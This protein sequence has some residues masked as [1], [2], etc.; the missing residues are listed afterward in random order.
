MEFVGTEHCA[1]CRGQFPRRTARGP[2]PWQSNFRAG[3]LRSPPNYPTLLI[4]SVVLCLDSKNESNAEV[5]ELA[6]LPNFSLDVAVPMTGRPRDRTVTICRDS[7]QTWRGRI[8][9]SPFCLA[10]CVHG[11]CFSVLMWKIPEC[12]IP[13]IYKLVRS[14]IPKAFSLGGYLRR[15]C[16]RQLPPGSSR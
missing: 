12:P 1:L 3:K 4:C 9:Q 14:L 11:W 5:T 2:D 13:T 16:G 6:V 10:F 7:L 15:R 8:E